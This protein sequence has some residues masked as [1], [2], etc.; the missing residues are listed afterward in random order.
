MEHDSCNV[1]V[2]CL[3]FVDARSRLEAENVNAVVV[4]SKCKALLTR[5]LAGYRNAALTNEEALAAGELVVLNV[6]FVQLD[7]A[8]D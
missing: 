2:M 5:E 3:K 4:A 6:E 1:V 7:E 8:V